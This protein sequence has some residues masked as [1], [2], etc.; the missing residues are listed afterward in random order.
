LPTATPWSNIVLSGYEMKMSI[1]SKETIHRAHVGLLVAALL[2]GAT[3]SLGTNEM[4]CKMDRPATAPEPGC[5]ACGPVQ[6][7]GPGPS[8]KAA[9][10][11]RFQAPSETRTLSVSLSS[12]LRAHSGPYA[13]AI[14]LAIASDFRNL[15]SGSACPATG[16]SAPRSS[17]TR[18]SILRL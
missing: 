18:A 5:G 9:S 2:V 13:Q 1:R 3:P 14:A 10:C 16:A 12:Q 17:P 11:C 8:L 4:V 7:P 6:E 15:A